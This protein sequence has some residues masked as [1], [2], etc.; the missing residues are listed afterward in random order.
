MRRA[1]GDAADIEA[2]VLPKSFSAAFDADSTLEEYCK[3]TAEYEGYHRYWTN[4]KGNKRLNFGLARQFLAC[5]QISIS[6]TY[7]EVEKP[8]FEKR[9]V[10]ALVF[11]IYL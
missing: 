4:D 7:L 9:D 6:C 10:V 11:Q 2:V 3:P 1:C 5:T 8:F